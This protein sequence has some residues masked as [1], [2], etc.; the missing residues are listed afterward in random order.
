[1]VLDNEIFEQALTLFHR[2]SLQN[3]CLFEKMTELGIL[4]KDRDPGLSVFDIGAGQ[5]HLPDL[6]RPH[7]GKLILLEPNRR[8]VD[9]LSKRFEHIYP[10]PW[11]AEALER[12]RT[13]HPGGFDLVTMS[14]MLYHF[15]GIDDIH[16]KIMLSL[17]SVNAGGNLVIAVNQPSAPTSKAG[18]RFQ[19]EEGRLDEFRTNHDLLDIV[20]DS[21]FFSELSDQGF[22]VSI[23]PLDTPLKGVSDR[24]ELVML[25]RMPLLNPL[26]DSPCDLRKI[27]GFISDFIDSQFPD[28]C[29]PATIPSMDNMICF[30]NRGTCNER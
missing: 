7:V 18:V 8:C 25:F 1:M 23:Y 3:D 11:N 9:V 24:E 27:D 12:V 21:G 5:G 17:S 20:N 26:S 16:E 14:H 29:Y 4:P 2:Y 28:L 19:M 15:Q 10:C 30:C 22:D 13:D 6:I